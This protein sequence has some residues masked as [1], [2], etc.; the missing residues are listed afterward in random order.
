MTLEQWL[1]QGGEGARNRLHMAAKVSPRVITRALERRATLA[2]ATKLHNTIKE[3]TGADVPVDSMTADLDDRSIGKV[4]ALKG[5]KKKRARRSFD[6]T[7]KR[8]RA[9]GAET[10]RKR[11]ARA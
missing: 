3:T 10:R 7:S 9:A 4:V 6:F 11:A 8:S 2:S 5:A 1:K